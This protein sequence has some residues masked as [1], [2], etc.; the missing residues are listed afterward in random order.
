MSSEGFSLVQEDED[1]RVCWHDFQGSQTMPSLGEKLQGWLEVCVN[2]SGQARV[3]LG[4]SGKFDISPGTVA[5]YI[6]PASECLDRMDS[7]KDPHRY[8]SLHMSRAWLKHLVAGQ[9]THATSVIQG[10]LENRRSARTA[11]IAGMDDSVKGIAQQLASPS[12]A[13][14]ARPLWV[15][16]KVLEIASHVFFPQETTSAEF[17]CHRQKRVARERVDRV[18]AALQ[19]DLENPPTLQALGREVGCS[20]FY[21]SRVFSEEKGMTI[22]RYLRKLRLDKAAELLRTGNYNVTEA[23][24]AVGYSSLSHFSKAFAEQF[25]ACPCVFPLATH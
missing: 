11:H 2:F 22:S 24:M 16:A 20:P 6:R 5:H 19:R 3:A 1:L 4:K 10:F 25:G 14:S 21:I 17:F 8:L 18:I 9:H 23:A 13:A 12:I 7:G 15:R